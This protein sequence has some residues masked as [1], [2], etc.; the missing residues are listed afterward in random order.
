MFPIEVVSFVLMDV[1]SRLDERSRPPSRALVKRAFAQRVGQRLQPR[2]AK[3]HHHRKVGVR[4]TKLEEA[5]TGKP[6][7][8]R[9]VQIKVINAKQLDVFFRFGEDSPFNSD[10]LRCYLIGSRDALD[11]VEKVADAEREDDSHPLPEAVDD[12]WM[13]SEQGLFSL[14]LFRIR[15]SGQI[16]IAEPALDRRRLNAFP[17][18]RTRFR[19]VTHRLCRFLW[20]SLGA[21]VERRTQ[22]A[23]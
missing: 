12:R 11:P 14:G 10:S 15:V 16:G 13:A 17:T 23:P 18:Y 22:F 21:H 1:T 5:L 9:L 8:Q 3:D 2:D 20:L 6:H 4:R 7:S 19:F